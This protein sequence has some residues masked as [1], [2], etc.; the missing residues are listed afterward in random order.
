MAESTV[1]PIVTTIIENVSHLEYNATT[2]RA[3]RYVDYNAAV[4]GFIIM[5]AAFTIIGVPSNLLLVGVF[6]QRQKRHN[7][8]NNL[9]A[10]TLAVTDAIICGIAIPV[11]TF[12]LLGMIRTDVGCAITVFIAHTTVSFQVIIML[13]VC[14]ERY[15]AV[16]RPFHRWRIKHVI[17]FVSAAA[18]YSGSIS[19][20]ALPTAKF[21]D[22]TFYFCER[23][24]ILATNVMDALDAFSWFAV[25]I[26]MAV[27]YTITIVKICKQTRM[28]QKVQDTNRVRNRVTYKMI[29]STALIIVL[30]CIVLDWIGLDYCII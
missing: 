10:L 30:Y 5:M 15:C 7:G 11:L 4:I 18:V 29:S 26:I 13:G 24:A 1:L 17:V 8:T 6:R 22:M 2:Q 21:N 3:E 28:K 12:S 16:C 20:V 25:V 14:I 9:F 27:L 19:A 23:R